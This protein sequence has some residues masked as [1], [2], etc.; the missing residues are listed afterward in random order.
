MVILVVTS[1]N[2]HHSSP[3]AAQAVLPQVLPGGLIEF[4][5]SGA[6]RPVDGS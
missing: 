2:S 5:A 1:A 3:E 6:Y 4:G